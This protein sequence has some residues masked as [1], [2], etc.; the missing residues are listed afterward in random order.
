MSLKELPW[1]RHDV[2]LL[3]FVGLP[4]R[5]AFAFHDMRPKNLKT[6]LGIFQIHETVL[7]TTRLDD[8]VEVLDTWV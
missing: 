8:V 5:I 2:T 7:N 1:H 4:D 6:S 3:K